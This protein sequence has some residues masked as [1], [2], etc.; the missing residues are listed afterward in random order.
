MLYKIHFMS[1]KGCLKLLEVSRQREAHLGNK[2]T[3]VWGIAQEL[4]LHA[5]TQTGSWPRCMTL[6]K[7]V[8]LPGL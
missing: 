4:K 3:L 6:N 8:N 7:L 2:R 5:L 1:L